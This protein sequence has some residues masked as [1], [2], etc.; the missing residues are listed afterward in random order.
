MPQLVHV[1]IAQEH[2]TQQYNKKDDKHLRCAGCK[3]AGHAAGHAAW[4]TRSCSASKVFCDRRWLTVRKLVEAI[5]SIQQGTQPQM[6]PTLP[7]NAE[8]NDGFTLVGGSLELM[9]AAPSR[10]VG[11]TKAARAKGQTHLSLPFPT[12]DNIFGVASSPGTHGHAPESLTATAAKASPTAVAVAVADP[13]TEPQPSATPFNL[14]VPY[15]T[16]PP[17]RTRSAPAPATPAPGPYEV[18]SGDQRNAVTEPNDVDM[19]NTPTQC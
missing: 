3:Q 4:M 15:T 6:I 1:D 10:P 16:A 7:P 19:A 11:F 17:V 12:L 18:E 14:P 9:H 5:L 13:V 8:V 2:M